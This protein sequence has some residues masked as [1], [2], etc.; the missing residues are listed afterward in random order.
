MGN[1]VAVLSVFL[2]FG[3][4]AVYFSSPRPLGFSALEDQQYAGAAM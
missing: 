4:R 3:D 2:V 1:V